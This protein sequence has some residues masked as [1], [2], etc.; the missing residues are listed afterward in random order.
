MVKK[1]RE[2]VSKFVYW[3]PRI[4]SM[5]FIVFLSLFS[6]DIL[7]NGYNFW[8]TIGGLFMHNI[9]SLILICV[10]IISWRYEIV[11][12]IV[13]IF[14]GAFYFFLI[15]IH[16]LR[17]SPNELYQLFW[18]LLISGPAILIGVLFL[19]NWLKRKN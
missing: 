7:G 17:S 6:L 3:T 2:K 15:L 9:P 1:K 10:L 18:T 5:A 8:Q 12:G 19:I 4:L 14:V 16:I 13:F 11:G